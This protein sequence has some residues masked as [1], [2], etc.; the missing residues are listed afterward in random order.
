MRASHALLAVVLLGALAPAVAQ[1]SGAPAS[2]PPLSQRATGA[3]PVRQDASQWL[4][5]NLMGAKVV[6]ASGETV[7]RVANLIVNDNG[8]V[9]SVV[10]AVGGLFG[11]GA[12]DVAVTYPSLNIERNRTGDAIERVTVAATRD[13]LRQAVPFKS[14]RRQTAEAQAKQ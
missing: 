2:S 7:G 5:S 10:I 14:L 1:D 11:M 4:G 6:S 3:Y 8:A 13:D 12:K 9:E